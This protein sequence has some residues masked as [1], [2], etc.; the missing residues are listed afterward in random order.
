MI[1][2][3][4]EEDNA[5]VPVDGV[6]CTVCFNC[7]VSGVISL[8]DSDDVS[9]MSSLL[10]DDDDDDDV[11]DAITLV[12]VVVVVAVRWTVLRVRSFVMDVRALALAYATCIEII[13]RTC[14]LSI[15]RDVNSV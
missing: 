4:E 6:V 1:E 2:A 3:A 13:G 5:D 15:E 7:L 12:V 14:Q 8:S 9:E 11:S 10:D